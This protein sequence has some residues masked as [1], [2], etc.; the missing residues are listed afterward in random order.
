MFGR[1]MGW[2]GKIGNFASRFVGKSGIIG[3]IAGGVSKAANIITT[4]ASKAVPI[5]GKIGTGLQLA[6][7]TGILDKITKGRATKLV[8]GFTNWFSPN[9]GQTQDVASEVKKV[10]AETNTAALSKQLG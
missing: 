1:I 7:K 9:R 5:I 4:F 6:Y 10:G 8:K 3:K 2:V